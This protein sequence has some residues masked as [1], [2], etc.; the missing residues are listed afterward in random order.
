MPTQP[1]H[2]R[3]AAEHENAN[4]LGIRVEGLNRDQLQELADKVVALLR[5]ELAIERERRT[6]RGAA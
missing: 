5:H 1:A 4:E 3:D 2:D 6:Q